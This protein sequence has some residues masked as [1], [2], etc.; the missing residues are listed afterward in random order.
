MSEKIIE[1]KAICVMRGYGALALTDEFIAWNKS[2][3]NVIVFGVFSSLSDNFVGVHLSDI[4]CVERYT[5]VGGGGIK[6]TLKTGEVVKF[7]IK[8]KR[9]FDVIYNYLMNRNNK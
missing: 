9:N 2:A 8:P 6:L 3:V 1:C 7:S 4:T 5:F